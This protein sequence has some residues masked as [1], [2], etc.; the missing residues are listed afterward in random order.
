M[1]SHELLNGIRVKVN[2]QKEMTSCHAIRLVQC[3]I[4]NCWFN[5]HSLTTSELKKSY[6]ICYQGSKKTHFLMVD[7][8]HSQ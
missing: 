8:N 3:L 4:K 1:N 6:A 5:N 2:G 7:K